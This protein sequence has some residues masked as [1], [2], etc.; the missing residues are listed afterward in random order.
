MFDNLFRSLM[1]VPAHN[2]KLL[3]SSINTDADV[4]LLDLEDSVQPKN[5]KSIAIRIVD[6]SFG[7]F[8][9]SVLVFILSLV[10]QKAQ[11]L[12]QEQKLT[13]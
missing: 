10:L 5:N 6:L 13:V 11:D 3:K 12:H 4:L 8:I 2:E 9:T 7:Y 1:F